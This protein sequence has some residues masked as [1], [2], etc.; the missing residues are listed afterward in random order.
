VET[1]SVTLVVDDEPALL[2]MPAESLREEGLE[3]RLAVGAG[4]WRSPCLSAAA[5]RNSPRSW[6]L[7]HSK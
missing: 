5:F 2:E 3:E 4:A 6:S 7:K 1:S